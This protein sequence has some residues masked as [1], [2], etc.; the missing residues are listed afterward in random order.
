MLNFVLDSWG[1]HCVRKRPDGGWM[2]KCFVFLPP[3][4]NVFFMKTYEE[5]QKKEYWLKSETDLKDLLDDPDKANC[6]LRYNFPKGFIHGLVKFYYDF[7]DYYPDF[8]NKYP[9]MKLNFTSVNDSLHCR[10]SYDSRAR[11]SLEARTP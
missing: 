4:Q 8:L 9:N 3:Y 10:N 5:D 2:E 7:K 6:S 11:F 1:A